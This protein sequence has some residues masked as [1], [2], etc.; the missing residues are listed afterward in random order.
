MSASLGWAFFATSADADMI[1]PDWQ[2]PH[3]TTSRSS[4][5]CCTFLPVGVSPIASMVV[6]FFPAAAATGVT[7]ERIGCPS[8][9]TV[10]APQRAMPQPNFVPVKPTTSRSTH[11]M[12][13]SVGTSTV[14]SLPLM[15]RVIMVE[16]CPQ[17]CIVHCPPTRCACSVEEV[18]DGGNR[19]GRILL[20]QPVPG[21]RNDDLLDVARGSAHDHRRHRAERCLAAH[22]QHRHGQHALGQERLV[23]D[24]I[25]IEGLELLEAG[26]HAAR[27]RVHPGVVPA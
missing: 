19:G 7:H 24:G 15:L 11:R 12:G 9:C 13:M 1:W 3:C 2:Y 25:L 8:R 17:G 26:M 4:H 18:H 23:V 10:H 27:K 20:H 16:F 5:A 6:I 21:G 22:R 14:W